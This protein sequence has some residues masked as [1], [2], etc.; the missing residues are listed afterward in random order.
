V[1][2]DPYRFGVM[3]TYT[4]L[5]A[6]MD[7]T[8]GTQ[9]FTDEKG[10]SYTYAGST[11]SH[12]FSVFGGIS[13]HTN[14]GVSDHINYADS[15]DFDFGSGD[16]TVECWVYPTSFNSNFGGVIMTKWVS[17]GAYPPFMLNMGGSGELVFYASNNG[18][19]WGVS[20]V[21]N[22]LDLNTGAWRHIAATRSGNTFR[23]FVDGTVWGSTATMSGALTT[24][25]GPLSVC[26]YPDGAVYGFTGY[27]DEVRVSKGIARYTGSFTPSAVPFT[28]YA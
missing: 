19:S 26:G 3:D 11:L 24:N 2:I 16:F 6:H 21:T 10:H 27:I 13:V 4:V 5:L 18:S 9:V 23:V 12:L 25:S 14:G 15:T 17:G 20:L 7:G 22:P 28:V 8:T 1:I